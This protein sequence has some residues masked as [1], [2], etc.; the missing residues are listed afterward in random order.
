MATSHETKNPQQVR[1]LKI[2]IEGLNALQSGYERKAAAAGTKG[3]SQVQ[4]IYT[5]RAAEVAATRNRA[6]TG[7]LF[8]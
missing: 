6:T 8:K 5:Q 7:D 4:E 1:D 3:D 2:I